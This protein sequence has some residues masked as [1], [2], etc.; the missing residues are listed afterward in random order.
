MTPR[1]RRMMLVG[2]VLA[3]VALS[4]ALALRAF[5]ENMMA[6]FDPTQVM[7]GEAPVERGF[8]L[9]GMVE[10]GSV[11]REAGSL[12]V[13]FKVTDFHQAVLVSYT[14]VLPDLFREG[15][16]VV[17]IGKLDDEGAFI[18][19]KVLAKHDE[20]YMPPEVAD[21]VERGRAMGGAV[22]DDKSL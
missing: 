17:A 22:N 5:Q 19:D 6:F 15:Q 12:T 1:R 18:A 2:V 7:A 20:N 11:V 8:R 16:G 21:A 14:G 10:E 4:V 9:G 3:G 13:R